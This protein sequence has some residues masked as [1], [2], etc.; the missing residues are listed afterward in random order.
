[1]NSSVE[2]KVENRKRKKKTDMA[3]DSGA[4]KADC[5]A[6]ANAKERIAELELK[7][8]KLTCELQSA[9]RR[10]DEYR[11]MLRNPRT[12]ENAKDGEGVIDPGTDD[13]FE[14]MEADPIGSIYCSLDAA[15][16]DEGGEWSVA[17][18][19]RVQDAVAFSP[20]QRQKEQ[21]NQVQKQQQQTE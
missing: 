13:T 4:E 11:I 15:G 21:K 20:L 19:K 18:E 9:L 12:I 10:I 17:G 2:E 14:D 7:V 6:G 3:L 16:F 5:G 1:M 8:N